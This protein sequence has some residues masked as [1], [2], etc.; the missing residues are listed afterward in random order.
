MA[1]FIVGLSVE[2]VIIVLLILTVRF[3]VVR[4]TK[5]IKDLLFLKQELIKYQQQNSELE[6]N[7]AILLEGMLRLE[8][9]GCMKLFNLV[10]RRNIEHG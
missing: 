9:D 8:I 7:M 1:W 2:A 3:L 5:Y 6:K 10:M 4:N